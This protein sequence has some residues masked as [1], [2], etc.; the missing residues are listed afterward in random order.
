VYARECN[1]GRAGFLIASKG[2]RSGKPILHQRFYSGQMMLGD[3]PLKV[4]GDLEAGGK[5]LAAGIEYARQG[6]AQDVERC[7]DACAKA[8]HP[9]DAAR[10][11]LTA[12]MPHEAIGCTE[13]CEGSDA[14]RAATL[15][16]DNSEVW[17]A[18]KC[19]ERYLEGMDATAIPA[20][21]KKILL[22][23]FS[24]AG[25]AAMANKFLG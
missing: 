22:R 15:F 1:H 25:D 8:G 5:H 4:A 19:A 11:Y 12:G 16:L 10:I 6:R 24:R 9:V 7:A 20:D 23:I 21:E 14:F 3:N 17:A 2:Q 13:G 18:R